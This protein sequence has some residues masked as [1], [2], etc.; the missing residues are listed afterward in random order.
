MYI[1]E[2]YLLSLSLQL[3]VRERDV[4]RAVFAPPLL[5]QEMGNAI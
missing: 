2:K 5:Y 3:N 4:Q 1:F